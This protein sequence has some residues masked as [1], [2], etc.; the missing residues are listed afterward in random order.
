VRQPKHKRSAAQAAAGRAWAAAGRASQ[1]ATRRAAIQKTGKPPP[2][3]KARHQAALR[4][5]AAGRASQA[6]ARAHLKPLP[7]KKPAIAF[8]GGPAQGQDDSQR[9]NGEP[10]G[11]L[12]DLPVCAAVAVAE[13]LY[14]ATGIIVSDAEILELHSAASGGGLG[15]YLEVAAMAG[16]GGA[17]LAG[18]WPCD[19]DAYVPGLVY[20]VQLRGGYHAVLSH[21]AGVGMVSWGTLLR[22][23]G[24]PCE[25]WHLEWEA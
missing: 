17:R 6:R 23:T 1:A 20:G 25:A 3:S 8:P 15:D 13:H 14:A 5:A 2:V 9:K 18:F 11:N 19:E 12:H 4:W 7:K 21:P 10:A 24:V 22:L 16:L